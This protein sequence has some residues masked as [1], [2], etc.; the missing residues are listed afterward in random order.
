[1]NIS[2]ETVDSISSVFNVNSIPAADISA[3]FAS[4]ARKPA[5]VVKSTEPKERVKRAG[6]KQE[7]A[8]AIFQRHNGNRKAVI[9]D[10]KTELG[11]SDAGATTYFYNAKRFCK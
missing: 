7:A 11:M 8:M 1:M 5:K 2:Q 4:T 10:I 3:K 9:A 6:T